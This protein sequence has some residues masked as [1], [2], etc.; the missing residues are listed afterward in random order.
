MSRPALAIEYPL[1][2]E[3]EQ[4]WAEAARATPMHR[5]DERDALYRFVESTLASH[6][7][8]VVAAEDGRGD[9]LV[10]LLE[11]PKGRALRV[12]PVV[13]RTG[14]DVGL[15]D[16]AALPVGTRLEELG[17]EVDGVPWNAPAEETHLTVLG[18]DV[19]PVARALVDAW[20][21][22][23]ATT[24]SVRRPY[25]PS[26]FGDG[27][28]NGWVQHDTAL[29]YADTLERIARELR[30]TVERGRA[31]DQ[32]RGG[33]YSA[34]LRLLADGMS[35]D[36]ADATERAADIIGSGKGRLTA[37]VEVGLDG[38]GWALTTK[39]ADTE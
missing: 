28:S 8:E 33:D 12:E 9:V 35:G 16:L 36:A 5:D 11:S 7:L 24:G 21:S 2:R 39:P 20:W 22:E 30:E 32:T 10:E 37:A 17:W 1:T 13:E 6:G 3:L 14:D 26:L 29:E 27:V 23:N 34:A 38:E 18:D 31:E 19:P 15:V 4:A 25:L